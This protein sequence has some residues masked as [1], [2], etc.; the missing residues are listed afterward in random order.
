MGPEPTASF[1]GSR[2]TLVRGPPYS[3][4]FLHLLRWASGDSV[5][6]T[7]VELRSLHL[8]C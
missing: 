2:R 3:S 6:C 7:V 4:I 8:T 5:A 1:L